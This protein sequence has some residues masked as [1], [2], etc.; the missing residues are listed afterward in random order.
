MPASTAALTLARD[1]W[2]PA[3]AVTATGGRAMAD[4][5]QAHESLLFATARRLCRDDS[6]AHDLVHDTYVRA[7]RNWDRYADSGNVK[8]WLMTIMHNLFIDRC[9]RAKRAPQIEALDDIQIAMPEPVAPPVWADVTSEEIARALATIGE[10][11]R[12][13]YE[14]HTAGR[15]YDEI[16]AELRIAKATVGTRLLRARK[17]LKDAF[18]RARGAR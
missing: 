6:D 8:A 18:I 3:R 11:F 17:K 14:L 10:E 12:T 1:A 13:V 7:L 15:S 4:A 2:Q 5:V 9:R 16:A